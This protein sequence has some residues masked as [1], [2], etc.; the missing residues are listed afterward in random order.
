MAPAAAALAT[1]PV[2]DF[3]IAAG[4][5]SQLPA[6]HLHERAR[7][8]AARARDQS[9]DAQRHRDPAGAARQTLSVHVPARPARA[10]DPP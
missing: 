10:D 1:D 5:A 2:V 6:G 8:Q 4:E 7:A 3:R 9:Q